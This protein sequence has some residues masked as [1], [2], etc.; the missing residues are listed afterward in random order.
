MWSYGEGL[1]LQSHCLISHRRPF[2]TP[3]Y[4][5]HQACSHQAKDGACGT[6]WSSPSPWSQ[7][8]SNPQ[9]PTLFS[10]LL[11]LPVVPGCPR[12]W[13]S[14]S[15]SLVQT[16][17]SSGFPMSE[18]V[19]YIPGSWCLIASLQPIFTLESGVSTV[20][21]F[22]F[23]LPCGR[24]NIGPTNLKWPIFLTFHKIFYFDCIQN[25]QFF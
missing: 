11:W 2:C 20:K 16:W 9:A 7:A 17:A 8:R 24:E 5:H 23:C 13:E 19:L 14:H 18:T 3:G 15:P 25:I 22:F 4:N 10:A 12:A 21:L 1:C 6:R